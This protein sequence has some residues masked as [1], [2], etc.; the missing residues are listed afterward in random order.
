LTKTIKTK[1]KKFSLRFATQSDTALILEF[2][3][4]LAIYEDML[5]EV[6]ATEEVLAKTLF[7]DKSAEVIIGEYK[8]D[9]IGFALFFQNFSTFLGRPGIYLEDLYICPEMRGKGLGKIMLSYL[10]KL[11]L[12]R[13]CGRLEWWCL[14]WNESSISFYKQLGAKAMKDW[15]V[16]RVDGETLKTLA[17]D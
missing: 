4:E 12:K 16:Y 9:P 5:D 13:K 7:I 10:A 2:I 6:H 15:T 11:A 17:K 1:D 8:S 14:D 3:K